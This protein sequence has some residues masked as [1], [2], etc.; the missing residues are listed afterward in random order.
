[1]RRGRRAKPIN[2]AMNATLHMRISRLQQLNLDRTALILDVPPS[3]LAR[4]WLKKGA[5]E[6]GIDLDQPVP[7]S[8]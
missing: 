5:A 6:A 7:A 3:T 2:E 8:V 4:S 1:M